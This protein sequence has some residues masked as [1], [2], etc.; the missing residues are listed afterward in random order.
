[1]VIASSALWVSDHK[2]ST[3][4]KLPLIICPQT[5]RMVGSVD[6]SPKLFISQRRK[7]ALRG[8]V[9]CPSKAWIW[10]QVHWLEN[11]Y[12]QTQKQHTTRQQGHGREVITFLGGMHHRYTQNAPTFAKL[13]AC[14]SR[15]KLLEGRN[16]LFCFCFCIPFSWHSAW[17]L[18]GLNLYLP[19]CTD[20]NWRKWN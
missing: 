12:A 9:I 5:F 4:Y 20:R 18:V 16:A 10:T 8:R 2:S 17:H 19:N 11:Q 1:M 15:N 6:H 7:Q 14:F 13:L 3:V